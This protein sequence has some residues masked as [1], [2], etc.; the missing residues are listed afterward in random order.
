MRMGVSLWGRKRK[1]ENTYDEQD[2]EGH[3]MVVNMN[4]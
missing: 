4:E 2:G 3:G 1:T